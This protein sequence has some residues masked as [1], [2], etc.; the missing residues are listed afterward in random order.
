[1]S[2][3]L[4]IED[5]SLLRETLT[6]ILEI[7]GYTVIQARDGQEGVE[8]FT[9]TAPD[10]VICDINMPKMDGFEV[11][12]MLDT[13]IPVS[14]FPPF[15]FQSAKTEPENIRNGM[16]L[17]AAD[18]IMKPYSAPELLKVIELR[19][20]KR[21]KL[22]TALIQDERARI[23]Q[24]LHDGVQSL[25]AADEMRAKTVAGYLDE[26][27]KEEQDLI[28]N[29]NQLLNEAITEIRS[30]LNSLKPELIKT[31]ELEAYLKLVI[32][33]VGD[34]TG[35]KVDLDINVEGELLHSKLQVFLCLLVKEMMDN[36]VNHAKANTV[37]IKITRI[38]NAI[39]IDFQDDGIGF[40]TSEHKEGI[41]LQDIR[42][43]VNELDG[44]FTLES[45]L[46]QGT[47]M[48][49]RFQTENFN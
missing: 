13:L 22:H 20:K 26:M 16:N 39:D 21:K 3:I 41:G 25:V 6:D 1:M 9:K 27:S 33:P 19:L 8:M 32:N 45:E 29:S 47:K 4:I 31:N 48:H 30:V 36:T 28:K 46:N 34:S 44:E 7:S 15:I 11:L 49:L 24:E 5:E 14:K 17:G 38:K 40:N 23:S 37:S 2:T 42:K 35:I 12:K 43:R 18:F 10:L